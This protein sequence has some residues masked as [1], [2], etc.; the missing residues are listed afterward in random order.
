MRNIVVTLAV[1]L[2]AAPVLATTV[3]I[4]ATDE[5]AGVVRI[6]YTVTGQPKV[7]AVALDITVTA[8][9][10]DAISNYIKGES[11]AAAPGFGIFPANFSR[12]ITVDATT[13]EVTSWDVANYTPVADA[14]DPGALPGLGTNGITIEMGALYYPP[15]DSSVNAPPASGMLC[16]VKVSSDCTLSLA[17]NATR[18]GVVLTDPA[19]APTVTLTGCTVK[20]V[21]DCFPSTNSAYNDWVALGKPDCWCAKPKGS[22]Y[23]C[24]GDADGK[25]QGL[26]KYRV[27][28][29]DLSIL[30]ANWQKKAGDPTLNACADIDHMA[31]GLPKYRVYTNDL[32][33]LVNNWTKKD[34][35]LPGNCP[36]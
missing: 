24:D 25:T 10:I 4:T 8:G 16:K 34:A 35:A 15:D 23:Q 36:R 28:T 17:E 22:G 32:T 29:D 33:I 6:G 7:R 13:G 18:G 30:V 31:Q 20:I 12:H 27:Y 21:T 3:A 2:L 26:P 14:A 1:L 5:G 11:T 9:T 19:V